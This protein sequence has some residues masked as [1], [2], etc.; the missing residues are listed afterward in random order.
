MR[1]INR[2]GNCLDLFAPGVNITS[3]AMNGTETRKSGTSFSS[4]LTA[5][6]LAQLW[7]V[8]PNQNASEIV[9]TLLS[10]SSVDVVRGLRRLID[11]LFSKSPNRLL[12]SLPSNVTA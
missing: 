5:G 7:S 8:Y 11:D 6:S 2:V 3:L 12:Y 1:G 9:D 10:N 4:P